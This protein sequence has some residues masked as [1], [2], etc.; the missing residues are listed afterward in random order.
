MR[1]ADIARRVGMSTNAF[2]R[3]FSSEAGV[4]PQN[5]Y[6]RHRIEYACLLLH[7][8]AMSIDRIADETGFCDR[9]HFSR[10]FKRLR[11]LGPAAFRKSGIHDTL[12]AGA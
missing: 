1:N 5:W 10:T 4:P 9:A 12:P 8:A 7:H 6:T 2:I 3:L 11:G